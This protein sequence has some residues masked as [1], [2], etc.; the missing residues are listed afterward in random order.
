L[1]AVVAG[2]GPAGARA[3]CLGRTDGGSRWVVPSAAAAG[4][5]TAG[6]GENDLSAWVVN[7]LGPGVGM[8]V[9]DLVTGARGVTVSYTF[10]TAGLSNSLTIGLREGGGALVYLPVSP[11]DMGVP[12][13][14]WVGSFQGSATFTEPGPGVILIGHD[15][16]GAYRGHL[17]VPGAFIGSPQRPAPLSGG[18]WSVILTGGA[19]GAVVGSHTVAAGTSELVTIDA[20]LEYASSVVLPS[21]AD[22]ELQWVPRAD[23]RF[24]ANNSVLRA[25]DDAGLV[26]SRDDCAGLRMGTSDSVVHV[27]TQVTGRRTYCGQTIDPA[28]GIGVA[29]ARLDAATGALVGLQWFRS[30]V[31][32]QAFAVGPG[33]DAYVGFI[34]DGVTPRTICGDAVPLLGDPGYALVA[35]AP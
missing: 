25:Y 21:G 15:A 16:T 7:G 11:T 1:G 18:R 17:N 6:F 8:Q 5:G 32:P 20:S 30:G 31:S 9:I 26:W 14:N 22:Y 29:W 10:A 27:M 3:E 2:I 28:G 13:A 35:L 12:T 23:L 4:V 33:G 24:V 19:A 34:H